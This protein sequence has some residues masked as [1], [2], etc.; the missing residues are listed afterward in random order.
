[1]ALL[2]SGS[3]TWTFGG[4]NI[5]PTSECTAC[6]AGSRACIQCGYQPSHTCDDG[7]DADD[8]DDDDGDG[9]GNGDLDGD[10]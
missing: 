8:G 1:M 4:G 9:D 10:G 7:G 2:V 3:G 6:R 5:F